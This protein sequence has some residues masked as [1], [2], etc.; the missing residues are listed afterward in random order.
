MTDEEFRRAARAWL[1]GN[2]TGEFAVLAG[3]GGP[4]REHEFVAERLAWERRLGEGGWIGLGWPA[5]DGG[6]G[7]PWAQQVIFHEEYA[8]AGGPVTWAS[9]SS[10]RRC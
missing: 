10:A 4:G 6:R 9:S 7:L 8:R 5:A 3:K 2:L 1:A